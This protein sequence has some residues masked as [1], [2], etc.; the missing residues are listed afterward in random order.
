MKKKIGDKLYDFWDRKK[1]DII[2]TAIITTG[3]CAMAFITGN[4]IAKAACKTMDYHASKNFGIASEAAKNARF[5]TMVKGMCD[6]F[7]NTGSCT[8]RTITNVPT[9]KDFLMTVNLTPKK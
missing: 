3:M 5:G 1:Y 4:L 9:G 6:E 7:Y 2:D 8:P